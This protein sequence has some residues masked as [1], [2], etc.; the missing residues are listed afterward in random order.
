MIGSSFTTQHGLAVA[1]A[2]GKTHGAFAM[3][4]TEDAA[5]IAARGVVRFI[6]SISEV[7]GLARSK[8]AA[9]TAVTSGAERRSAWALRGVP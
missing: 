2:E 9:G 7:R 4:D 5:L 1:W 3:G 8:V 6:E